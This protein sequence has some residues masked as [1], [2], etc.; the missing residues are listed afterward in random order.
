VRDRERA[1]AH[2][3]HSHTRMRLYV[4]RDYIFSFYSSHI[5]QSTTVNDIQKVVNPSL[6]C[7][8]KRVVWASKNKANILGSTV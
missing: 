1:A 2:A 8:Y 4:Y 7:T 6:I 5:I 3:Q